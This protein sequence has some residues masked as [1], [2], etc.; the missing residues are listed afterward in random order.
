VRRRTEHEK[1]PFDSPVY[2]IERGVDRQP[3]SRDRGIEGRPRN[4]AVL[5]VDPAVPGLR[6]GPDTLDI[7]II[8][9]PFQD[10]HDITVRRHGRF[11]INRPPAVRGAFEGVENHRQPARGLGVTEPW[12]VL[13]TARVGSNGDNWVGHDSSE[14]TV[15][16]RRSL[17]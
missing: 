11:A 14:R 10:T 17:L 16:D 8:M 13:E 9:D 15:D 1:R 4:P 5:A 2:Q 6:G 3:R 12:V 7:V